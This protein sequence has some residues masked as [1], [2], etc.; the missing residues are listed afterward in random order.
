MLE[1]FELADEATLQ[2]IASMKD[3]RSDFANV[4][5]E[6]IR[7]YCLEECRLLSKAVRLL[8][9]LIMESGYTTKVFYSPGSLAAAVMKAHDVNSYRLEGDGGVLAEAIEAAYV[10]ARAEVAEVGPLQGGPFEEW[11]INSAY[12][13]AAVELP[14]F[15]HG[16]W[17]KFRGEIHDVTDTTLVHVAWS[18]RSGTLWGPFPVRPRVGSLRFPT[19]GEAWVWGREARIGIEVCENFTVL[20]GWQWVPTC[21]HRPFAYLAGALPA[22]PALEGLGARPS[23]TSTN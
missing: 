4:S 14:C 18:C 10:G 15:A 1:D 23:S 21:D 17:R 5:M 19:S 7:A 9:D 22:P 8:L 12:P 20:S 6:Q 11:D 16:V 13:A 3:Q 2:R